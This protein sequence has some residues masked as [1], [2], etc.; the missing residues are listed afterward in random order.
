MLVGITRTQVIPARFPCS[1]SSTR[2]PFF[3]FVWLLFSSS[4]Q[5]F[6]I[7]DC[8]DT[9]LSSLLLCKI[10]DQSTSSSS[11]ASP[12]HCCSAQLDQIPPT[13]C[14]CIVKPPAP[15]LWS[16]TSL[17]ALLLIHITDC[18]PWTWMILQRQRTTTILIAN[19]YPI[20]QYQNINKHPFIHNKFSQRSLKANQQPDLVSSHHHHLM[21][22]RWGRVLLTQQE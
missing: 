12:P 22:T 18:C 21:H 5:A 10:A 8:I 7:L 14:C 17:A 15:L 9:V 4:L 19:Q 1:T 13:C 11:C 3:L 20:K 6:F 16:S 2:C